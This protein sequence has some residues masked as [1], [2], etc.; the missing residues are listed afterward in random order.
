MSLVTR[1]NP[2]IMIVILTLLFVRLPADVTFLLL[3]VHGEHDVTFYLIF[4]MIKFFMS[5]MLPTDT[6]LL[7]M[8]FSWRH[9]SIHTMP[10][11]L[12][13]CGLFLYFTFY[14]FQIRLTFIN[15]K[16]HLLTSFFLH[17]LCLSSWHHA[18]Y[19]FIHSTFYQFHI[20][21]LASALFSRSLPST[22]MAMTSSFTMIDCRSICTCS[23][24]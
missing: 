20:R 24:A 19:L 13:S 6:T 11:L 21:I 12:T 14:Q 7:P 16:L 5:S 4:T 22:T 18:V 2:N 10:E 3:P 9:V 23:L 8:L 1:K 17:T 15:V